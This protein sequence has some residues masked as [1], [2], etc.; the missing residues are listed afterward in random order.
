[1]IKHTLIVFLTIS[2]QCTISAQTSTRNYVKIRSPRIE[3]SNMEELDQL[4]WEQTKTEIVYLDAL[5]RVAQAVDY[6]TTSTGNS[7]VQPFKYDE[8]G[9]QTK[10]YESYST[11]GTLNNLDYRPNWLSELHNFYSSNESNGITPCYSPYVEVAYSKS[12]EQRLELMG[13]VGSSWSLASGRVSQQKFGVELASDKVIR[14]ML[15]ESGLPIE[16][17]R[18]IQNYNSNSTQSVT[19]LVLSCPLLSSQWH[20]PIGQLE[21]TPEQCLLY[22]NT[23][24]EAVYFDGLDPS[25][26]YQIKLKYKR[27]EGSPLLFYAK[28]EMNDLLVQEDMLPCEGM[29]AGIWHNFESDFVTGVNS[30]KVQRGGGPTG[31]TSDFFRMKDFEI[32]ELI[33]ETTVSSGPMFYSDQELYKSVVIDENQLITE[34][35]YN[36][37]NNLVLSRLRKGENINDTYYV[38]N[39]KNQLAAVIPPKYI[40]DLIADSYIDHYSAGAKRNSMF[41]YKYDGRGYVN[42]KS[43]PD[44]GVTLF[45]NNL[46]GKVMF[47]QNQ[48]QRDIDWWSFYSYDY[49]GRLVLKGEMR[50]SHNS[51]LWLNQAYQQNLQSVSGE[52]GYDFE[53]RIVQSP[54]EIGYSLNGLQFSLDYQIDEVLYYD[55]YPPSIPQDLQADDPSN[56]LMNGLGQVVAQLTKVP[57]EE[58]RK[59]LNVTY[60]DSKG[61][62]VK[63]AKETLNGSI[64]SNKEFSWSGDL[65]IDETIAKWNGETFL[66]R[67]R[68]TYEDR[69]SVV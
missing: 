6:R 65:L 66:S 25:K 14:W 60:Y 56:D 61:R 31:T 4:S 27:T 18:P 62:P 1:M 7:I 53:T 11:L 40:D 50:E 59:L 2:A 47:E 69:K 38:Y 49:Q 15:D 37:L 57:S 30:I 24:Y 21:M 43:E 10:Y 17:E 13:A 39:E 52:V 20:Y 28:F 36:S 23:D 63:T 12:P 51:A 44:K 67:F 16:D 41:L 3:C 9:L 54:I 64:V 58:N 68:F 19:S 42:Y 46:Q 45:V 8:F 55:T 29:A 22:G 32:V 26:T 35:F 34:N 48:L 5:G 33:Q